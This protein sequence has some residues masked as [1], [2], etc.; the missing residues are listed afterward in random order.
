VTEHLLHA[1]V[2]V[3]LTNAI[4]IF[5]FFFFL[6]FGNRSQPVD[7]AY[8]HFGAEGKCSTGKSILAN[9]PVNSSPPP[10]L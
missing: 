9:S 2:Y 6:F 1:H 8:V 7:F 5:L 3:F 10:N 4:A